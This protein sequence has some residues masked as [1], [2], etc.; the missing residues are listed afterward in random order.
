MLVKLQTFEPVADNRHWQ[1]W[2]R[3]V[4]GDLIRLEL[5]GKGSRKKVAG[6]GPQAT[7]KQDA[8]N[9]EIAVSNIEKAQLV[10]EF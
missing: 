10:P 9:V 7:E 3:E 8:S 5:Q 4:D 6:R 2:L 1:G